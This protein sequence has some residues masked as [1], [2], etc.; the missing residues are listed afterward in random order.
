VV[1]ITPD[2][3]HLSDPDNYDKIYYVGSKFPKSWAFYGAFGPDKAAFT[4]PGHEEHRVRRAVLNPFFSQKR[5]FELEQ[6]VQDKAK[7]VQQRMNADLQKSGRID[8]HHTFRA[9]SVD[10]I[11]D[12]AFDNCYNF[13]DRADFGVEFFNMI[14][15]FGPGFWFF[16]MF[17]FIQPIALG[18]PFWMAKIIG[19]PL[20]RMLMLQQVR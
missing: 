11:T 6:I 8:L 3:V 14:R 10:V 12:Y 1:R 2:E 9:V 17:P 15:D 16:Q 7:K 4:T 13:L 18:V 5:V 19:G 20:M